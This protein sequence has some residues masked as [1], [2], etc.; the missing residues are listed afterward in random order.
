MKPQIAFVFFVMLAACESPP[1]QNPDKLPGWTEGFENTVDGGTT[2]A[3][4]TG[5]GTTTGQPLPSDTEFNI[6]VPPNV[7]WPWRLRRWTPGTDEVF[8]NDSCGLDLSTVV[9]GIDVATKHCIVE[10]NEG[11]IHLEPGLELFI[12]V[13][14]DTC[15]YV[16]TRLY[17]YQAFEVGYGTNSLSYDV[18]DDG[19]ISNENGTF[20]GNPQCQYDYVAGPNC[21]LGSY[22]LTVTNIDSDEVIVTDGAWGGEDQIGKCYDGGRY[23]YDGAVL[24]PNDIPY[25]PYWYLDGLPL[26]QLITFKDINLDEDPNDDGYGSNVG[27][28]NYYN[29]AD[30][31]AEGGMPQSLEPDILELVEPY[32]T[33]LCT[34]HALEK[35]GI[36]YI[37]MRDWN[38]E[39]EFAIDGDHNAQE[40]EFEEQ[41]PFKPFNDV[42]DWRDFRDWGLI[43]FAD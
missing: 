10:Q 18:D 26:D 11:D 40:D 5:G 4:T 7:S 37:T 8:P 36:L 6:T 14:P 33:F 23:L 9:A 42:W 17:T 15:D 16:F 20:Q 32:Y 12:H 13:P 21:C 29:P 38:T 34:D 39:A 28:A 3:G 19:N 24:A 35:V 27:L 30:H 25:N 22:T 2:T 41:D 1:G 31:V 43:G